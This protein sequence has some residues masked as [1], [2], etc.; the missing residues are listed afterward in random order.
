M[1]Y[2]F[3]EPLIEVT[4]G[5]IVE[6]IHFGAFA[7]V[8]S[9][10]KLLASVGDPDTYT[11]LRSSAKPFQALP[12]VERGGVQYFKITERELALI[13]A[14]HSGTDEHLKVV[15]GLQ[16]KIG[17]QEDQLLCGRHPISDE[18]TAEAML[19][20]GEQPRINRHNCSGKHSGM[21]AHAKMRNL[22]LNDYI[23]KD[24]P[25]QQTI[26]KAFSEMCNLDPA[27]VE[28]GIDGCSVPTFAVPIRQAAFAI[29]RLCEPIHL[30]ETRARACKEITH[31][32]T[33]NP[34]MVAGPGRFDTDLMSVSNGMI[35]S[36]AGAEGYQVVGLMPGALG[37]GSPG[38]GIALK[39][40]DG[41]LGGHIRP[42][43]PGMFTDSRAR[44]IAILSILKRMG[45]LSSMQ[46]EKLAG[47]DVRSICNWQKIPVGEYRTVF[48]L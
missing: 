15:T 44:P 34:E 7:V 21:L 6:S 24:H 9:A 35:L 14:S 38:I 36:K 43:F 37:A 18:P 27:K 23:Q 45:A 29:A 22:S 2:P 17:I 10:G 40:S 25:V 20:R 16:Q 47:Y 5:R 31:A 19:L 30:E 1:S 32:M 28:V 4:R 39:I 26:L 11:F 8:D 13:C 12:F 48:N 42:T 3:Y 33:S 41:D 46:L